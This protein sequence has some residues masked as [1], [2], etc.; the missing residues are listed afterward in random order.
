MGVS[1]NVFCNKH[2]SLLIINNGGGVIH[3]SRSVFHDDSTFSKPA[4]VDLHDYLVRDNDMLSLEEVNVL[5]SRM[6]K[7]DQ[8]DV[9]NEMFASI[10]RQLIEREVHLLT[11]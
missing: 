11:E 6:E 1:R 3:G 10:L 4:S 9:E 8:H 7:Y 5:R 2:G